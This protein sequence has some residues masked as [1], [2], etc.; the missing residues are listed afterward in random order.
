MKMHEYMTT[1]ITFRMRC[2]YG[3]S[4]ASF[5]VL[6]AIAFLSYLGGVFKL[7]VFFMVLCVIN[8][9]FNLSS[10]MKTSLIQT[11]LK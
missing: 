9:I 10:W 5:H 7:I 3:C 4:R 8:I 6:L 1:K 2:S 11:M